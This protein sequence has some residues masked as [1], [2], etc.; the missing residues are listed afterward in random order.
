MAL[1]NDLMVGPAFGM[2]VFL[3]D[4]TDGSSGLIIE[5]GRGLI[6]AH[7]RQDLE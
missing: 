2:A 3:G 7:Q 1:T 4:A 6:I 5:T